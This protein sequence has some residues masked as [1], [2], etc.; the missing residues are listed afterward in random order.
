VT[1]VRIDPPS[2]D[3]MPDYS[4]RMAGQVGIVSLVRQLD[5]PNDQKLPLVVGL[6]QVGIDLY[7]VVRG[8]GL[9]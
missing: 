5:L 8:G 3:N 4:A 6:A 1:I 2:T 7:D 9:L